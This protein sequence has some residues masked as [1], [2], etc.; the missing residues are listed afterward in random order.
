MSISTN[1]LKNGMTLDLPEGLMTVVDFQHVKPGKGGAFVRTRLKNVRTGAVLDRTFR[2]DEK[3]GFAQIDKR[4]MQFLYRDGDDAVFM[5]NE[6]YDQI[7]VPN[8]QLGDA[9]NY[10][11]DGDT[12]VLPMYQRRDHRRGAARRGR[13]LDHGDR[14]GCAGRSRSAARASRAKLETGLVV[15]VPLFV[16]S[17]NG[18]RSTPARANT[19][20][21]LIPPWLR[22][23]AEQPANGPS[24]SNTNANSGIGIAELLD[25]LSVRP[26][27]Y[28]E[29]LARGVDEHRPEIDDAHR[30]S[31]PT[32]WTIDRMPA[33]DRAVLRIGTYELLC[34]PDVPTAVVINEAVDLAKQYSTKDSGRFVNGCCSRRSPRTRAP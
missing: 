14:T 23:H 10:L 30:A 27:E 3:V 25:A 9:V 28:A 15:Q 33:I 26:D 11:S 2:A 24:A 21:G 29:H 6:C 34:E 19:C 18:S 16:K 32:H 31:S 4:E 20:R 22:R 1:E 13:A 5:D 12:V 17:A 8:D 7:N